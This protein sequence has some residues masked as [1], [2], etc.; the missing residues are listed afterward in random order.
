MT[1]GIAS[2]PPSKDALE[3]IAGL[4]YVEV[5]GGVS[6]AVQLHK[7]PALT[8]GMRELEF[9][10]VGDRVRE[11]RQAPR[12]LFTLV[13]GLEQLVCLVPTCQGVG[14]LRFDDHRGL[15]PKRLS[16]TDFG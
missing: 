5:A 3:A 15:D 10:A 11:R 16:L 9:R 6:P 14:A 2:S 8:V 1:I 13:V 4:K 7:D 12:L